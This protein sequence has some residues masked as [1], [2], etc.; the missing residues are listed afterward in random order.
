M[1]TIPFGQKIADLRR[2][3]GF[4]QDGLAYLCKI[5][6]RTVQRIET[7]RVEPRPSTLKMIFEILGPMPV[8]EPQDDGR[9]NVHGFRETLLRWAAAFRGRKGET[10]MKKQSMLQQLARSRKDRKIAGICGGLGEH[11]G[12][13]AWFWRLIFIA[14]VFVHGL[15]ALVYLFVWIFMPQTKEAIGKGRS[16]TANWLQRLTRSATDKKIGGVCGGL[17]AATA[18]PSWLWRMGF[19][20]AMFFYAAG[21]ILYALLWISIPK[22]E[23]EPARAG[24]PAGGRR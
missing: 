5:D 6:V 20:A 4:S 22:T 1:D 13:P 23:M 16:K 17:G 9:N 21:L 19:V 14:G 7:G 11:T 15:G 2:Q 12:L 24:Q 8:S 18:V 3:K 10:L